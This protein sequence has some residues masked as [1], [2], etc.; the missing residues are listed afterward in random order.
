MS[1]RR[2]CSQQQ[3]LRGAVSNM[4]S[5]EQS[6]TWHQ[7]SSQ[8]HSLRSKVNSKATDVQSITWSQNGGQDGHLGGDDRLVTR[9]PPLLLIQPL[10]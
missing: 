7:K 10:G 4:A 8:L 2:R 3:S 6:A 5:E 1:D 9:L